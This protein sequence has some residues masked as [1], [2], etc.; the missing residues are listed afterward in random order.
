[1]KSKKTLLIALCMALTSAH[2]QVITKVGRATLHL[3]DADTDTPV[4]YDK[5]ANGS[6]NINWFSYDYPTIGGDGQPVTL[7]ALAC[8][9]DNTGETT[10]IN[11]VIVGC[12]I[13]I[14]T[15]KECPTQYN[16]SGSMFS[17]IFLTMT[18]AGSNLYPQ[19]DL[20]HHN[21]VIL[22]DYEGYG[23]TKD[24]S[25][26][27]LISEINARQVTDAVRYGIQLYQNDGQLQDMR[28]PFRQDWRSICTG[29][30]Q[31]GAVALS[32]QRYIEEQ[33]LSD[34]L[35][36]AGS[37]CGDGPYSPLVNILYYMEQ[38]RDGK[39]LSMPVV[40]SLMLKGL[41]EYDE[42]MA[43][44][45]VNDFLV[46]RF[47]ETGVIDWITEKEKSTDDI[48]NTWKQLYANGKGDDKTYFHS[49]LTSDGKAL[50]KNIVKPEIY[51]YY[52]DLLDKYPHYATTSIPSPEGNSLAEIMHLALS[53]N[54]LTTGWTPT[55][56]VYLYHSTKDEVVPFQ[57]YQIAAS[58]LGEEVEFC[59][60]ASNGTHVETGME[61]FFSPQRLDC[62]RA[63]ASAGSD[64]ISTTMQPSTAQKWFDIYGRPV[65]KTSSA[66]GILIINGKKYIFR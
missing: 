13:T 35:H 2:A 10:E 38:D 4:F 65:M 1:M 54:D 56:P 33:G 9:P 49:V 59:P 48:T 20:A 6:F 18:L 23:I 66:K 28:R 62:I 50:L 30:S 16:I 61:F 22:P 45:Q 12:H 3:A 29:Y 64:G 31:G 36:L 5:G 25:H 42:A 26:P 55:H 44:C 57:N 41:C 11:N 39:E 60:S 27:Y 51:Q 52:S 34:E 32:T 46:E 37:V 40:L 43:G 14:T 21:L 53:H 8:M 7:S 19:D 63:L 15:N 58:N 47:L 17:D 24:R